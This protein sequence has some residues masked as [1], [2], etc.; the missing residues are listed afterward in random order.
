FANKKA[1]VI[2]GAASGIGKE[3]ARVYADNGA[4]VALSDLD[5]DKIK[6]AA[7]E[8]KEKGMDTIGIRCDVTKENEVEALFFQTLKKFDR[9]DV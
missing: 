2:T 1:A 9:I 5:E 3:L 6:R 4:K 7:A 8:L